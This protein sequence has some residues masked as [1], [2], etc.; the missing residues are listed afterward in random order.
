MVYNFVITLLMSFILFSDNLIAAESC[1]HYHMI[2]MGKPGRTIIVI[3]TLSI[4]YNVRSYH[5]RSLEKKIMKEKSLSIIYYHAHTDT[6]SQWRL[7][8]EVGYNYQ[9]T[10]I[11]YLCMRLF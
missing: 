1:I 10:L 8:M 4:Q 5:R 2:F 7:M 9:S 11:F 6:H 3:I